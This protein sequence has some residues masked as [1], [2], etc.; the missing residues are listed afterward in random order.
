MLLPSPPP[1]D[2]EEHDDRWWWRQSSSP[3]PPSSLPAFGML[4]AA[5][6]RRWRVCRRRFQT[7]FNLAGN[8]L[9]P[10]LYAEALAL[11]HPDWAY[12]FGAGLAA[13]VLGAALRLPSL[14]VLDL[15]L[16]LLH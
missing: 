4:L 5:L 1:S 10:Q 12:L 16:A 9:C 11:G 8:E 7:L 15:H 6:A 2:E 3:P 14:E 13:I